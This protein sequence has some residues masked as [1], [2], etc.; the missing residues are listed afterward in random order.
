V[1]SDRS[2]PPARRNRL[3]A[4][5]ARSP[6]PSL[7]DRG[8]ARFQGGT[9]RRRVGQGS[10]PQ[11]GPRRRSDHP[12]HQRLLGRSRALAIPGRPRHPERP[13]SGRPL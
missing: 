13:Y 10:R 11:P 3:P 8:A 1:I 2:D 7:R 6:R 4:T 5:P 12:G 9:R